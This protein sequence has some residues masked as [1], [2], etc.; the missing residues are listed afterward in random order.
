M[1]TGKSYAADVYLTMSRTLTKYVR[2]WTGLYKEACEATQVRGE[3]SGEVLDLRMSCL[4]ERLGEVRALSDVFAQ[5]TGEVVENAVSA[6]NALG[7]LSRCSDVPLLRAVV[8][9]PEDKVTQARVGELR[10]RLAKL[11]ASFDAGRWK[12]VLG[13]APA[14]VA[15]SRELGYQPLVAESLALLGTISYKS[16]NAK[17]AERAL[18]EAFLTADAARHDEVRAEASVNL[19]FVV[20]FLEGRFEEAQHWARAAKGV[21]GR[22]GAHEL[23]HAWLLNNLGCVYQL[24][25]RKEDAVHAQKQALAIKGRALGTDHPDVGISEVNLAVALEEMGRYE[26]ALEHIN[27]SEKLVQDGLGGGH[28]DLALSLVNKGEILAALDQ[29]RAARA[30]FE[31]ALVIW[32][33]RAGPGRA[34]LGYALTG[35]GIA[36]LAEHNVPAAIAPLERAF[37]IRQAREPEPSRRAETHFALARALWESGRDRPGHTS[38]PT[39][40][41]LSILKAGSPKS[42]PSLTVGSLTTR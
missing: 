18:V 15:Q 33:R 30:S 23:L 7:S 21:L 20:G 2:T 3:Q 24:Q 16:N 42:F 6:A 10:Q 8:R 22:L 39:W 9:P 41:G 27:R 31:Q 25:G 13:S 14:L 34:Y 26:E 1:R 5:A 11:K 40:R 32:E 17:G 37:K 36:H 38:W 35:I 19:V 29:P 28:P 12:E 4:N